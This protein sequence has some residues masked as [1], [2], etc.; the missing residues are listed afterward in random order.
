MVKV[1]D[2]SSGQIFAPPGQLLNKT[3]QGTCIHLFLALV[4]RL[5]INVSLNSGQV[6]PIQ[7]GQVLI[8]GRAEV[9]PG[10][11]WKLSSAK[12]FDLKL[13]RAVHFVQPS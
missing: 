8:M 3:L 7:D 2:T 1:R 11:G 12:A 10:L 6:F 4:L 13:N 5:K 9:I